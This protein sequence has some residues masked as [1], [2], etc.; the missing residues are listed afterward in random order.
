MVETLTDDTDPFLVKLKEQRNMPLVTR[1]A[2]MEDKE[3]LAAYGRKV[4]FLG[5]PPGRP[6]KLQQKTIQLT[7]TLCN[8]S[9]NTVRYYT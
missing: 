8:E 9:Y 5:R 2:G 4:K 1:Y 7:C 6:A 3:L